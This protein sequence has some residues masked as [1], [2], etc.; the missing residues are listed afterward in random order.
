MLYR[1]CNCRN[2]RNTIHL[3]LLPTHDAKGELRRGKALGAGAE[4]ER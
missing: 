4:E 2:S 3:P 1:A